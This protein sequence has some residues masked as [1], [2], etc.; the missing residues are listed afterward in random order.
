M[1]SRR[2]KIVKVYAKVYLIILAAIGLA[3]S[4]CSHNN[5]E[6]KKSGQE[7]QSAA[8][9]NYEIIEAKTFKVSEIQGL[10]YPGNDDSLYIATNNGLKM[11]KDGK[12]YQSTANLHNYMGFQAVET[13]FI[14]SGHPQ[15][16]TGFKDPLGLVKSTDKGK[17]LENI[18]FNGDAAYRFMA[19]GYSNQVIYVLNEQPTHD[20]SQGVYYSEDNGAT[21]KKSA[22]KGFTADSLGMLAVH[23]QHGNIMAMS[24]R[25]GIYYST[26]YGNTMKPITSPVMVTALTFSGDSILYSSVEDQKILFKTVNPETKVQANITIPFLNYD[27]P[28]TYMAV[29]PKNIKQIAFTT[30]RNDVFISNDGGKNWTTILAGGKKVPE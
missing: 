25:S 28:V 29:N 7:T 9:P 23:P 18:A 11:Y 24:T 8:K 10:G 22:F 6:S 2:K 26:N 30:Y 20:L 1:V 21:W 17:S 19:A 5:Q 13:G 27:N 14:A 3:V 12:W 16:G 4:G 15:K